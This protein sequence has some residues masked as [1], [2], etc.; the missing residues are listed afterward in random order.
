MPFNSFSFLAF[1]GILSV[2]YYLLPHR[3][4]WPL[5][6][7]A[8]LGFYATFQVRFLVLLTSITLISYWAGLSLGKQRAD[9][10]R[11]RL[12][13]TASVISVVGALL[14]FKYYDFLVDALGVSLTAVGLSDGSLPFPRFGLV[15]A[16]G[17][18]LYAPHTADDMWQ[19]LGHFDG[20]K[21]FS[22][23][24]EDSG[25]RAGRRRAG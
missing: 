9:A 4:R 13:L 23:L 22:Q 3:F 24:R 11:H 16:V 19:R 5:L 14:T 20:T 7:I 1:F 2:V 10:R 21:E 18:S 6:L 15:V 12:V 8:S 17:L 25:P